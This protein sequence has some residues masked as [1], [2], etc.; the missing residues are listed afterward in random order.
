MI[1]LS[2]ALD[3]IKELKIDF[4]ELLF[5]KDI[6]DESAKLKKE[7][8]S[9]KVATEQ[10][11]KIDLAIAAKEK[12]ILD[13][14]IKRKNELKD[15]VKKSLNDPTTDLALSLNEL[16]TLVEIKKLKRP[17]NCYVIEEKTPFPLDEL[18]NSIAKE[19]KERTQIIYK[20]S[21]KIRHWSALDVKRD[22]QG[23]LTVFLLDA[24][25]NVRN[26]NEDAIKKYCEEHKIKLII[27]KGKIQK[28]NFT[29]SIYSLDHVFHMSKMIDLYEQLDKVKVQDPKIP[30]FYSVSTLD[31]PPVF[32]KNAQST[33]FLK[34][35][36]ERHPE[37]ENIVINKKG[38]T[39]SEY[40]KS[41]QRINESGKVIPEGIIYK[42]K[43]YISRISEARHAFLN[44]MNF[45]EHLS[46]MKQ[47]T[48]EMK[49]KAKKND[50]YL[51]AAEKG[52]LLC[53]ALEKAKETWLNTL[54]S[55]LNEAK[56]TFY[57]ECYGAIN[58][59]KET[60]Q[61][62]RQ[63]IGELKKFIHSLFACLGLSNDSLRFFAT[64]D[65]HKKLEAM[66]ED[67]QKDM[68]LNK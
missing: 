2:E 67:F 55:P 50:N 17:I 66:N 54:K 15:L 63:W 19:G 16:T 33:T 65:S 38:Q 68:F 41:H 37:A 46:I 18:L 28:D 5:A 35:Y 12:K 58:E 13:W 39:L 47:K 45:D 36:L 52:E 51:D 42:Y 34:D 23:T 56:I 20:L 3:K 48:A 26:E 62:H 64:T 24:P 21:K 43:Q 44:N 59:A 8:L 1:S 61:T 31:L 9:I 6:D 29:C 22:S 60:L 27:A 53:C 25:G 11:P 10:N 14:M 32:L 4:S 57:K 30:Y 40:V 7:L 49:E